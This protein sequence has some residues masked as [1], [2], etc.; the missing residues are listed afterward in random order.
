MPESEKDT[1]PNEKLIEENQREIAKILVKSFNFSR[2]DYPR[3]IDYWMEE[4]QRSGINIL[5][6]K[7]SELM[8]NEHVRETLTDAFLKKHKGKHMKRGTPDAT[9]EN[10]L[11]Q[12]MFRTEKD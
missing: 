11:A 5:Q 12:A 7:P 3:Q 6:F 10:E 1:N 8:G 9:I 2:N 4:A